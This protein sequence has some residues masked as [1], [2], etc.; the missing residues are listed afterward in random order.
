MI[1][2]TDYKINGRLFLQKENLA[3]DLGLSYGF[4][5][6]F[7]DLLQNVGHVASYII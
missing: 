7:H 3:T 6:H 4:Q 1:I 5:L 2:T